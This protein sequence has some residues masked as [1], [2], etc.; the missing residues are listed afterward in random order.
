MTNVMTRTTQRDNAAE[1]GIGRGLL[2]LMSV[3]TGLVAAGNYFAQ[4]LLDVIRQDLELST[5]TAAMVVTAAQAGYALG[6]IML[7][8]LGDLL[9]RRG[10]AVALFGAT[11]AFLL[12]S[13][14]APNGTV[15]LAGTALA[16]ITSVAAQVLVTFA[17]ALAD[18]EHR[19]RVVGTVMSG[20]LL[21]G[22]LAR[23]VSG[24]LSEF[25]GWRTV[26][27]VNAVLLIVVAVLLWRVLPRLHTPAGMSYPALLRSTVVLFRTEP[28]LRWRAVIAALS[29][30]SFNVFWTSVT[31]LLVADHYRWSEAVIGL[32]GLVGVAGTI[33][34]PVAGRLADRGYVQWVAGIGT[35]LLAV[36]WVAI[37]AGATSLVWLLAGAIALTVAQQSVLNSNQNVIYALA[38]EIRNRLNSAFMTAFFVGGAAGSALT[39]VAWVRGGWAGVSALGGALALATFLVWVAERVSA[40]RGPVL[41][42]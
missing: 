38:P 27:F 8:P 25:G 16:A 35:A 3:S 11:A 23:T 28:V 36:S 42:A 1:A 9:E 22:L 24:M 40:R 15:L 34:T 12:M 17:V 10:L 32:F 14:T 41:P 21:G 13:A 26:Y 33:A 6:L 7:L 18:P 5:S 37:A 19:G 31:F 30:A 2:L 29:L 39:A 20:L 4:P